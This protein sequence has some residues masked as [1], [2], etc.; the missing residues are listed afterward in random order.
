MLNEY[1]EL[2]EMLTGRAWL[3]GR[4]SEWQDWHVAIQLC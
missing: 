2:I 4:K 3:V 1:L